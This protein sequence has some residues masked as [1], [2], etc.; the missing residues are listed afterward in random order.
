MGNCL[1]QFGPYCV[2]LV[3]SRISKLLKKYCS[4]LWMSKLSE[5]YS[6]MF[7]QKLHPQVLID[8]E[9]W[10]HICM[11][12]HNLLFVQI[13]I[14]ILTVFPQIKKNNIKSLFYQI[15]SMARTA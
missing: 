9:R 12:S 13:L 1:M 14:T 2:E 10:T 4:G 7:S 6:V 5:V 3:Q 11:V 15:L 8:L